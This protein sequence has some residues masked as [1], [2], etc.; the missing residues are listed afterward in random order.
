MGSNI[1]ETQKIGGKIKSLNRAGKWAAG[2]RHVD[3]LDHLHSIDER[4]ET[5]N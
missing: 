2:R 3:Q 5:K 1:E 4:A